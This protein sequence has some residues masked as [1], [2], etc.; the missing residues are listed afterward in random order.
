MR[1]GD[2]RFVTSAQ[3]GPHRDLEALLRRHLAQPFR[4]P[5]LEYNR[6]AFAGAV[7]ARDRWQTDAPV[8]LDAGC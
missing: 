7:A 4:K 6:A 1:G 8:I 5:V 2:S 3:A